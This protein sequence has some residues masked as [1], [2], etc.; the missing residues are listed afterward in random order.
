MKSI[1]LLLLLLLL[2]SGYFMLEGQIVA[3]HPTYGVWGLCR[4]VQK[5][6]LRSCVA[7]RELL[8]FRFGSSFPLPTTC[9]AVG[10]HTFHKSFEL[11]RLAPNED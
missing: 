7:V 1:N 10:G 9:G 8:V 3:Q 5:R 6:V 2:L 4:A 11:R